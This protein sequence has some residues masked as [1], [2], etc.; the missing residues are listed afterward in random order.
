[1]KLKSKKEKRGQLFTPQRLSNGRVRRFDAPQGLTPLEFVPQGLSLTPRRAFSVAEAMIALLIGTIILGFS[2]PMITKQLKHNDFT[3]IQTQILNKKIENVDDK[4][5][6]NANKISGILDGKNVADYVDYIKRLENDINTIKNNSNIQNIISGTNQQKNYDSDIS[7][8]NKNLSDLTTSIDNI[9][10]DLTT[11]ETDV[12]DVEDKVKKLIPSGAILIFNSNSYGSVG[13]PTGWTN[14]SSSIAGKYLMLDTNENVGKTNKAH[15][16]NHWH[17]VGAFYPGDNDMLF[18]KRS[19]EYKKN[20]NNGDG[21]WLAYGDSATNPLSY[22]FTDSFKGTTIS[23]LMQTRGFG[24]SSEIYKDNS[25]VN[26]S[27][28]EIEV[29]PASLSVIACKKN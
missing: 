26:M 9:D 1:M 21:M 11:L 27:T 3:S 23:T 28:N 2:A 13:C 18:N 6:A 8:I 5:D 15:F 19:F 29:K 24:T 20:S 25:S 7:S 22:N 14:I 16:P 4:S 12:K 17:G 10:N